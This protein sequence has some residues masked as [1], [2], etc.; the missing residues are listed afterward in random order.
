MESQETEL[1]RLVA[2]V[3]KSAKYRHV[4]AG[5]VYAIG[6]IE[7][8]KGRTFKEAVKAT[9]SKLHQVA[10]A[11][12]QGRMH[13]DTWLADLHRAHQSGDDHHFRATC[14]SIMQHHASTRERLP[15]LDRFYTTVL[16]GLP[17]IR[18]V[19]D[20]AC[21]LNP[22]AIP[23]MPLT[24]DVRY[25]AYDVY[26]DMVA[27]LNGCLALIT[28]QGMAQV[29]NAVEAIPHQVADVAFILKTIPCLEQLDPEAG[30]HLLDGVDASYLVVSFPARSLGGRDKGMSTNYESRF[31]DLVA[32][33][34]WSI[35]RFEFQTELVFLVV[36]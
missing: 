29:W 18:C 19:V 17:P 22:L 31:Q 12:Q 26:A 25:H 4:D 13:Y 6:T 16:S 20:I 28:P 34:H 14:R 11:Y 36:R 5:L 15:I 3:L 23:W 32:G 10:G 8:S 1:D 9:K 30:R 33:R 35:H 21:G 7:L 24:A 27:F 2:E